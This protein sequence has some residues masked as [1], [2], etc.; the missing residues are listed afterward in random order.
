MSRR[1]TS[2]ETRHY[3]ERDALFDALPKLGR[4]D[5]LKVSMAAV[6][7][8]AANGIGFHPTSFQPV[9]VASAE[10]KGEPFTF[11]YISDSHLYRKDLNDRFVRS[12]L[13]AVDDVNHLDPK[14][15]FILY[16][17]DLAQLGKK[18]ELDLGAEILKNLQQPV[19]MMVGE[20]DWFLDMGARWRELFGAPTYSFD[21]K[22]VHFVVLQ[23]VNEKDFWTA[24]GMTPEERMGTV[25]GLDNGIQSRFEVG[26]EQREWLKNDLDKLPAS[27]PVIVFSHSPLYK[28]YR[29]WNFWTDD[30]DEVQAILKKFERVTVIHGHTHQM[31]TNR[32]GNIDFH[33]L[34]STAWPWPYAPE[35]LPKLTVQMARPDPFSPTDGCGDGS[36]EVSADGLVDKIY[37]LWN[38]NPI[39]VTSTYLA[40]NG[41]KD[42]PPQPNLVSF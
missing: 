7:A 29:N 11:A 9:S 4:R 31:L 32:I 8:A 35:G 30:A 14:P 26:A 3:E 33:G 28:Y 16:G 37:N 20:H 6:A 36:A 13:R 42:Q 24:R 5:F 40:S 19:R 34:L 39:E 15:D 12:L 21:H 17:G 1:F 22:G 10:T 27:Q 18:E 25:A 2:I 38:R 41:T 23:S